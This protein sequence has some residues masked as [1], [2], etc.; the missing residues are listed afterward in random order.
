M[1]QWYDGGV[2]GT[3][4]SFAQNKLRLMSSFGA[5]LL[6]GAALIVIIPEGVEL[7]MK[8]GESQRESGGSRI[9]HTF[10]W[11]GLWGNQGIFRSTYAWYSFANGNVCG[12][13]H[14]G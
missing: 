12:C 4:L 3:P 2:A 9:F 7:L 14:H 13:P 8:E 11:H 6:I 1:V 10:L 5:G